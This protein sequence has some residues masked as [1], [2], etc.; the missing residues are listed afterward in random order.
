MVL[1]HLGFF[2]CLFGFFVLFCFVLFCLTNSQLHKS[3]LHNT[4]SSEASIFS[5]WES[6]MADTC[7][8]CLVLLSSPSKPTMKPFMKAESLNLLSLAGCLEFQENYLKWP[9]KWICRHSN[10]D[11]KCL[12]PYPFS[13]WRFSL[14]PWVSIRGVAQCHYLYLYLFFTP[15]ICISIH[16][17]IWT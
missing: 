3:D 9:S 5:Q 8:E 12:E 7:H 14:S 1:R 16:I 15:T 2:V 6:H 17:C 13:F 11:S 4:S 10:R